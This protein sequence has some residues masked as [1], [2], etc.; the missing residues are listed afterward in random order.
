MLNFTPATQAVADLVAGV[1]DEL[2]TAPTPCPE[3][4]V[5]DLLDHLDQ[6]ATAFTAAANKTSQPEDGAPP[7]PD[8]ARLGPDWREKVT[9]NLTALADAWNEELAWTG[10]TSAGGQ[11]LPGEMAASVALDEV[12]IHGWDLAVAS[13]QR[14]TFPPDLL[15][16]AYGFVEATVAQNPEGTPGLFGAPVPVPDGTAR[17][18]RLIALSGRDP[19]WA[20]PPRPR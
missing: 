17:F 12:V 18:D 11:E 3:T 14:V 10:M 16:M 4:T 8:A 19:A 5:G 1:P 7:R 9:R 2:L 20:P 6:L 13:G 15:E